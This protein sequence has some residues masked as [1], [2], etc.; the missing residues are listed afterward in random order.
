MGVCPIS[1]SPPQPRPGRYRARVR[2][3]VYRWVGVIGRYAMPAPARLPAAL[4]VPAYRLRN[5]GLQEWPVQRTADV[6][7]VG[8]VACDT[9]DMIQR[10][11]YLFGV[12][13]PAISALIREHLE[14]G[15]AVVDVGANVGYYSLLAA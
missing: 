4:R 11:L 7:G 3:P 14:P 15:Q 9:A 8:T 12:W 13:E 5:V 1:E 2:V 10:Y 6:P